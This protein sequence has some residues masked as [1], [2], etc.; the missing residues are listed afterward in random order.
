MR[1]GVIAVTVLTLVSSQALAWSDAGHKIITSIAFSRL[2]VEQRQKVVEILQEHPRFKS[3]FLDKMPA[4]IADE[5]RN[6]WLLQQAS[7]W[8]DIA[9][10]FRGDDR[11]RYHHS[12]WHYIPVPAYLN[13]D[14]EKALEGKLKLNLSLDPPAKPEETMN[15]IQTIRLARAMLVDPAVP[16]ADKAVMLAWLFH[17]VG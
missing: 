13:D 16:K 4:D 10:G 9:R 11:T 8:P 1:R 5:E 14:D 7:V 3:D 6:E 17:V 12:T 2:T 15:A